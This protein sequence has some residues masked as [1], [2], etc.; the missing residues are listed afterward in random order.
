M[1][2]TRVCDQVSFKLKFT[3]LLLQGMLW[4]DDNWPSGVNGFVYPLGPQWDG[5]KWV[6]IKAPK[7]SELPP[8]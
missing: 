3:N 6:V 4:G 2:K 1:L 5:E 8:E 7:V